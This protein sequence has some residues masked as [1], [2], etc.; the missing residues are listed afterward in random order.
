VSE[1]KY[2]GLTAWRERQAE[3]RRLRLL[4]LEHYRSSATTEIRDGQEFTVVKIPDRYDF[5]VKPPINPRIQFR[6]TRKR[7]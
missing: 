5:T 7:T 1:S 4:E 2:N 6:R 3:A